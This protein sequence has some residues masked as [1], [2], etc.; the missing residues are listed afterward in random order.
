MPFKDPRHYVHEAERAAKESENAV[1]MMQFENLAN[2]KCHEATTAAEIW[3]QSK[4][5]LDAFVCA[6]GTGGTIAGVSNF[7]KKVRPHCLDFLFV[8]GLTSL[9]GSHRF[10]LRFTLR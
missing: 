9:S 5:E 1:L 7:L 3:M 2:Y 8:A 6:V 4:G 10:S